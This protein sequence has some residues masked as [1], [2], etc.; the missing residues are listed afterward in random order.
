M[1]S[2]N[3]IKTELFNILQQEGEKNLASQIAGVEMRNWLPGGLLGRGGLF[4][5]P[6]FGLTM[7]DLAMFAMTS[8][9]VVSE[10]LGV[11]GATVRQS[12]K[13]LNMINQYRDLMG[14]GII[15]TQD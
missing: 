5:I 15:K 8:P 4:S 3:E 9:K 14:L 13:F 1:K 12:T 11:L 7:S 6:F 10:F 2:D